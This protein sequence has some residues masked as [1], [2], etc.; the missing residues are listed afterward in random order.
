MSPAPPPELDNLGDLT[1]WSP[2]PVTALPYVAEFSRGVPNDWSAPLAG[3][4]SGLL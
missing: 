4:V 2:V 1:R 3:I